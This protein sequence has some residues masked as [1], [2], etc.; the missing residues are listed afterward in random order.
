[1]AIDRSQPPPYE[2][3]LSPDQARELVQSGGT[4]LLLDVPP[5]TAVGLDQQVIVAAEVVTS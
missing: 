1:M 2:V 3:N 5:G 4:L